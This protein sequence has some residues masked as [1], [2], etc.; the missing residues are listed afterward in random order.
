M[1]R[2]VI[3]TSREEGKRS[4]RKSEVT[5]WYLQGVQRQEC[6]KE[7][8]TR[9]ITMSLKSHVTVVKS[10]VFLSLGVPGLGLGPL[11]CKTLFLNL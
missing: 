4:E 2:M 3:L 9:R 10:S 5:S 8:K 11:V 6:G 7:K 1:M